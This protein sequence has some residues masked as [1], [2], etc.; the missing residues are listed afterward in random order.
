MTLGVVTVGIEVFTMEVEEGVV[1]GFAAG[2]A[3]VERLLWP[4]PALRVGA[5]TREKSASESLLR[6]ARYACAPF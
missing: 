1:V 2:E 5:D 3:E 4:A 6:V